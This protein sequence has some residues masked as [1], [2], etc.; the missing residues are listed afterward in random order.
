MISHMNKL[1][2]YICLKGFMKLQADDDLQRSKHA[3]VKVIR[4]KVIL[5]VFFWHVNEL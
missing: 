5:K 1:H 4:N 3:A 2:L